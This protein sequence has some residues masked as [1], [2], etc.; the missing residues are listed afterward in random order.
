MQ[1][2][3]QAVEVE[4]EALPA[5][6]DRMAARLR[7]FEAGREFPPARYGSDWGVRFD[8]ADAVRVRANFHAFT[9]AGAAYLSEL[10]TAGFFDRRIG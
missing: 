2:A 5:F 10:H 9:P 8:A 4:R 6:A 7:E 3:G 1:A